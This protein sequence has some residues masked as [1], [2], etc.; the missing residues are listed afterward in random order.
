MQPTLFFPFIHSYGLMLAIGFYA[1][2]YVAA[3]R[4][5]AA[6]VDP[7]LIGNLVLVSILAGVVG[8]RI[9]YF[10]LEKRPDESLWGI[11]KVWEGGLVFYG[12]L[13][14]AAVAD[15]LYVRWK[16]LSAWR[17]GDVLAPAI[18]I[19]QAFGRIGCFFN[20]CCFGGP[21][22]ASFPLAA[23]FPRILGEAIKGGLPEILGSPAYRQHVDHFWIGRAAE[24]SLPVHATQLYDSIG[25]F[26]IA[27]LL[28]AAT[29]HRKREGELFGWLL[30][31]HGALRL[32]VELVRRDT[33]V[34][35][36]GLKAGQIGAIVA[37]LLGAGI[38]VWLRRHGK[39]PTIATT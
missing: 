10:A 23:R 24:W 39:A 20:G 12:G 17:I 6:G 21:A 13:I 34:V 11:I 14:G 35:A 19:G 31:L 5:R 2:W 3:R 22:T 30:L 29:P 36:L 27:A 9:L 37:L 7:D 1:G 18:A 25:L 15:I 38:L 33:A 8:A 16:G 26:L 28:V 4:A 32:A